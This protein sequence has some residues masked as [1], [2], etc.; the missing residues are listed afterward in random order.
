VKSE[1]SEMT[2]REAIMEA[3]DLRLQAGQDFR[4][5]F[6]PLGTSSATWMNWQN[7]LRAGVP[8]EA[9]GPHFPDCQT[10]RESHVD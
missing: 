4:P 3:A 10:R 8:P 6:L 9:Y 5:T 2:D 7:S 1:L